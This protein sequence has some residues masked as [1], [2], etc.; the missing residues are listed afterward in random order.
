MGHVTV[1]EPI[2]NWCFRSFINNFISGGTS[3]SWRTKNTNRKVWRLFYY[4]YY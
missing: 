4:Y 3:S 1:N 2:N